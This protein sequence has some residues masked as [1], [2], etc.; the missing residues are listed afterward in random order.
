MNLKKI[1]RW[2]LPPFFAFLPVLGHSEDPINAP[3][4]VK[5]E[6]AKEDEDPENK[7]DKGFMDITDTVDDEMN[8]PAPAPSPEEDL[9]QPP[10]PGREDGEEK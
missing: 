5:D 3:P 9:F 10:P 2:T 4:P 8:S 7:P 6:R 1:L